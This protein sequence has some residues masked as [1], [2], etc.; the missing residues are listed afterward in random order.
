[1]EKLHEALQH[2]SN[3]PRREFL[4][5]ILRAIADLHSALEAQLAESRE[6]LDIATWLYA[7]ENSDGR[8]FNDIW[9]ELC[10][11][12]VA[13]AQK[14]IADF[15]SFLSEFKADPSE[16]I[17]EYSDRRVSLRRRQWGHAAESERQGGAHLQAA[18]PTRPRKK[19]GRPPRRQ[20]ET[21]RRMK[22][23]LEV[24]MNEDKLRGMP[25]TLLAGLYRVH[26]TVA[27]AARQQVLNDRAKARGSDTCGNSVVDFPHKSRS[28]K[29]RFTLND[30]AVSGVGA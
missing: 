28:G 24:G 15:L 22:A 21:I 29:L 16:W 6:T 13:D 27:K 3:E 8:E 5:E 2:L 1:M 20:Q 14:N 18:T 23:D 12:N 4:E 30:M 19:G 26:H 25:I 17:R 11:D 10:V 7:S 9:V